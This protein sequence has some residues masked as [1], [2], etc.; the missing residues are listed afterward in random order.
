MSKKLRNK[1]RK[2]VQ[3]EVKKE[4]NRRIKK[5]RMWIFRILI[6][7]FFKHLI[8]GWGLSDYISGLPFL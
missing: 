2:E 6:S 7:L 8:I 4:I 3:K 5:V 1:I